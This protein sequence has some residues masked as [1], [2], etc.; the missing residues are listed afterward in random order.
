MTDGALEKLEELFKWNIGTE[1]HDH[2]CDIFCYRP[3]DD[4][5]CNC[6]HGITR[7]LFVELKSQREAAQVFKDGLKLAREG[8]EW[9]VNCH[10][11]K[12]PKEEYEE[13]KKKYDDLF[14]QLTEALKGGN[15]IL[16]G[17]KGEIHPAE[18]AIRDASKLGPGESTGSRT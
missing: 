14:G 5:N 10:W 1:N 6:V 13:N 18:Q 9:I 11:D 17:E 3:H 15:L 16:A 4:K 2:D 12:L 7:K 8:T